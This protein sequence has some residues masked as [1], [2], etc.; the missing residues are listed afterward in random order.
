M[1]MVTFTTFPD[2]TSIGPLD[3]LKKRMRMLKRTR[4]VAARKRKGSKNRLKTKNHAMV[5]M[6]ELKDRNM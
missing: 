3:S 5:S 1:G 4:R 6:E 2:G